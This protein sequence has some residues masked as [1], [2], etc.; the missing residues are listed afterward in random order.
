MASLVPVKFAIFIMEVR[1]IGLQARSIAMTSAANPIAG[2][3]D[4][5]QEKDG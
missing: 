2:S 3:Q 5:G 1:L 4:R